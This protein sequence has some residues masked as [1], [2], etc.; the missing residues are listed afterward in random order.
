MQYNFLKIKN[1]NKREPDAIVFTRPGLETSDWPYN[2]GRGPHNHN[3][4]LERLIDW[5]QLQELDAGLRFRNHP[6]A[7]LDNENITKMIERPLRILCM[8]AKLRDWMV[9]ATYADYPLRDNKNDAQQTWRLNND[10]VFEVLIRGKASSEWIP[11]DE[12]VERKPAVDNSWLN[13]IEEDMVSIAT[14]LGI[15]HK[16]AFCLTVHCF[17]DFEIKGFEWDSAFGASRPFHSSK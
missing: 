8:E 2:K 10:G 14:K 6:F 11:H 3:H 17:D 13:W 9:E 1:F 4:N 12:L 5:R 16:D 15:S 7:Q